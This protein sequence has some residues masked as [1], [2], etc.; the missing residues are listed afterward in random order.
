MDK[1]KYT[2]VFILSLALLIMGGLRGVAQPVMP[3]TIKLGMRT[4]V[5]PIAAK[6]SE[7]GSWVWSGFCYAFGQQL[8]RELQQGNPNIRVEYREIVNDY[9]GTKY[10]RWGSLLTDEP[11]DRLDM[12]CGPNSRQNI[13]GNLVIFSDNSFYET[14]IK[15][16][17]KREIADQY[18]P[19]RNRTTLLEAIKQEIK[20]RIDIGAIVE[21]TTLDRLQSQASEPTDITPERLF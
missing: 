6:R 8:E 10:P 15:L 14:G 20:Q 3:E 2:V 9:K 18:L 17:M 1:L 11:S 7:G 19:D 16:L 21:T 5:P 13:D 12:Q 4:T